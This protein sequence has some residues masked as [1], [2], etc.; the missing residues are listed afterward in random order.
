M[1]QIRGQMERWMNNRLTLKD[2]EE[3]GVQVP[4][5]VC[6]SGMNILIYFHMHSEKLCSRVMSMQPRSKLHHNGIQNAKL[7]PGMLPAIFKHSQSGQLL[8]AA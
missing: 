3:K 2:G 5:K 4:C 1:E 6:D 8:G 7:T